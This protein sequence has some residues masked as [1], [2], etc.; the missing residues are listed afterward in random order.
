MFRNKLPVQLTVA[1]F[2]FF[3][4]CVTKQSSDS[5]FFF[6]YILNNQCL[7]KGNQTKLKVEV[8]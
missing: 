2:S 6:I 7:G 1:T 3:V 5:V 4:Q 8:D